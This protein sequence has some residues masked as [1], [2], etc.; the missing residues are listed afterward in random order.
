MPNFSAPDEHLNT[1]FPVNGDHGASEVV[2]A[3]IEAPEH[4][5]LY[6]LMRSADNVAPSFRFPDLISA[7]VSL[8]LGRPQAETALFRYLGSEMAKKQ[9]PSV[10]RREAMWR[11]QFEMLR[12]LQ[13]SPANKHPHPKF[14]LDQMT[15][16]CVALA[17]NAD[18]AGASVLQQARENMVERSRL[19][20]AASLQ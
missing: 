7:C 6:R 16:A 18:P 12:E 19:L 14:L 4:D 3:R 17:R 5:W 10:Q 11:A 13:R 15:T 8:T 9:P 2:E 20:R 1:H